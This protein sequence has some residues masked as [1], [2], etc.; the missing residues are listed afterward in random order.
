MPVREVRNNSGN[1]IGY[2]YGR[3]GKIYKK[4]ED[5]EKQERA[6]HASGYREKK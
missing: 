2:R 1:I 4:R 5:A 3:T 6:I